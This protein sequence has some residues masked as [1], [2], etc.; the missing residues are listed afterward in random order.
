MRIAA[1]YLFLC[2]LGI[3]RVC[4]YAQS[5]VIKIAEKD[6]SLSLWGRKE[7]TFWTGDTTVPTVN[8]NL[9]NY[10]VSAP[11]ESSSGQPKSLG[12]IQNHQVWLKFK[13]N[14]NTVSS[15]NWVLQNDYPMIDELYCHVVDEQTGQVTVK[16]LKESIPGYQRDIN[17]HQAAIPL[18]LVPF[19]N[20][21]VYVHLVS[22]DAKK[23]Q[24]RLTQTTYFYERY[25][26]QL[27]LWM[28]HLG[29]VACM[30]VVQLIFLFVTR[31]RNFLFYSLFMIGYLLVAVVGG[32]GVVDKWLWPHNQWFKS[33]GIVVVTLLSNVLGVLFYV[34]A[35]RLKTQMPLL[36]KTL[37]VQTLASMV[38]LYFVF[39]QDPPFTANEYA[40]WI[41]ILFFC[42][43][44]SACW[45]SYRRGNSSAI[46]YFCGTVAYFVGIM[47]VLFW[48]LNYIEPNLLVINAIHIG[49]MLEMV[50]FT[51]A[52]AREYRQTR[53]QKEQT[54]RDLIQTLQTQNQ[55]ISEALT[56]G[57]NLERKRVA[58]DLHDSLGGTLSAIRWTLSG[59]DAQKLS[60]PEKQVYNILREMTDD[61]H[62]KLRFLSHNLH[63]EDLE[64]DGL[65]VSLEKLMDKLN[66][67]GRTKFYLETQI[68]E[69]LE[70]QVE[71]ELYNICLELINNVIKHAQATQTHLT[72]KRQNGHIYLEI[73]DDGKGM[74][75]T[76][77]SGIGLRNIQERINTLKG[78]WQIESSGNG[79]KI[80][81]QI[82]FH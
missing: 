29:F 39:S 54:Q 73:N 14:K 20:Y 52:L 51:W 8:R 62:Q 37:W 64:Q 28:A 40:C 80:S 27:W 78:T 47:V 4:I 55:E 79:T 9:N 49:S 45:A 82:P 41:Y 22:A 10:I 13:V 23:M 77:K 15:V 19:K 59:I 46:Y 43:V 60:D 16:S 65:W 42:L 75:P 67:N 61:A 63:P 56:R 34:N 6:V 66:R 3:G 11:F 68:D 35:L 30:I 17:V 69:K 76:E 50:F 58:A 70:K 53:E 1:K 44:A 36:Y 72:L 32:Y 24:F 31:E 21:T 33:Y 5:P 57:Q 81:A 74:K 26:D 48:T 2:L 7:V 25:F 18:D 12:F 38:G 71:F